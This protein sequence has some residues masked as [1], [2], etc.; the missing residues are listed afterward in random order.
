MRTEGAVLK[1]HTQSSIHLKIANPTINDMTVTILELPT[2]EEDSADGRD[3][4][5]C[6]REE[7]EPWLALSVRLVNRIV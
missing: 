5:M 1:N 3:A 6:C 2:E 7:T 4:S